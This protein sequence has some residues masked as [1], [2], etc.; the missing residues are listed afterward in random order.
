VRQSDLDL[1]AQGIDAPVA[2]PVEP[3]CEKGEHPYG[4]LGPTRH[5]YIEVM[6][7]SIGIM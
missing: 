4:R 7:P 1:L 5:D 6:P 2:F 3:L